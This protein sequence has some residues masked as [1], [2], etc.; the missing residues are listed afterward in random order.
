MNKVAIIIDGGFYRKRVSRFG[1]TPEAAANT[2]YR[3][4][5]K[6][7][8]G[9]KE[10][11]SLYRV[12][13][14]DCPPS[15]RKVF[16]PLKRQVVDLQK[17]P[18]FRWMSDFLNELR[19][20]R[21]FA[22]RLGTLADE[23]ASYQLRQETIKRLLSGE[24]RISDLTEE[25]FYLSLHQKGIDTR[26]GIDI[27][28]MTLKKQ[29]DKIILI[30]GNSDFV[31]AA[32]F[33]RREGVDFVL[34]PMGVSIKEELSEHI[35]GLKYF[36]ITPGKEFSSPYKPNFEGRSRWESSDSIS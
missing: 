15:T 36:R 33:A 9:D 19:S 29:V 20:K 26:I 4:C 27:V 1:E 12:L 2:L 8:Y 31:P 10:E 16:H 30:A 32:K 11:S 17:E 3:Y 7:L 25:D 22:V 21:K 34:D 24:K 6:H 18:M 35:D 14:Y 5:Q 13:Y 23:Q 28:A